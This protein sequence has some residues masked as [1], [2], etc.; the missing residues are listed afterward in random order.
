[1]S[2]VKTAAVAGIALALSTCAYAHY[3]E[4]N[5]RLKKLEE[6]AQEKSVAGKTSLLEYGWKSIPAER[7]AALVRDAFDEVVHAGISGAKAKAGRIV[8]GMK[9]ELTDLTEEDEHGKK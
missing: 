7:K 9:Y 8:Q 4:Q 3:A 5:Y 6:K 2:L 1:M